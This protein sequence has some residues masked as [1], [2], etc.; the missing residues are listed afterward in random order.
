[1]SDLHINT[2]N[3]IGYHETRDPQLFEAAIEWQNEQEIIINVD[4]VLNGID[5]EEPS[6][7]TKKLIELCKQAEKMGISDLNIYPH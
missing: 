7:G 5:H 2:E 6:E 4:Y 1:M 3:K